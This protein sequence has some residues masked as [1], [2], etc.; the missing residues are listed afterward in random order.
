MGDDGSLLPRIAFANIEVS[1][2][3][4]EYLACCSL[5][6]CKKVLHSNNTSRGIFEKEHQVTRREKKAWCGEDWR[7]RP[8]ETLRLHVLNVEFEDL[9]CKDEEIKEIMD[10]LLNE[11]HKRR[12][13]IHRERQILLYCKSTL[14]S[15]QSKSR[16][17]GKT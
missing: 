4:I 5:I 6:R 10:L 17:I 11:G 14:G 13:R 2:E 16:R 1:L 9:F 7:Y 12:Q 8:D 3:V 15:F